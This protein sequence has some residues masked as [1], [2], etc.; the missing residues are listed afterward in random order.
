MKNNIG[1][2]M[3]RIVRHSGRSPALLVRAA[4]W[5]L[6]ERL[7]EVVP[8]LLCYVLLITLQDS[9]EA[10]GTRQ[11][12]G[13]ATLLAG[14]FVLQLFA[15]S[16]G[17]LAGF[18]GG[19]QIAAGY[20][21]RLLEHLHRLPWLT[22]RQYPAGQLSQLLTDDIKKIETLFTHLAIELVVTALVPL[23][24]ALG[25]LW[26]DW[27]L[28]LALLAGL[29]AAVL[30]I[31]WWRQ[32]F[33]AVSADK[34][35][36]MAQTAGKL[37]EFVLG[38]KTLR[39][40]NRGST[41]LSGLYEAFDRLTRASLRVET[42]G[43]GP[44]VGFRLL[45][46]MGLVA[47]LCLSA[48]R[49]DQAQVAPATLLLFLLLAHRLLLPLL[50]LA[51]QLSIARYAIQCETRIERFL[52][53]TPLTEPAAPQCPKGHEVAFDRVSFAYPDSPGLDDISFRV[54]PGTITAV[55]GPSGS[56]KSTL[57]NLV[58]RFGDPDD[59]VI[60]IGGVSLPDI[61]TD[62]VCQRLGMV[63]QQVQLF[64]GSIADNVRIGRPTASDEEVATAC[65]QAHCNDF[66]RALPQGY[67]TLVGEG[68]S[69]L[70]GGE[71]QRLSIARAFLKDAPILLLDEI[72][73][74]VDAITQHQIQASLRTLVSDKTVIVVAH[75]LTTIRDADQIL[76]MDK[77]RIVERGRHEALMA[78]QGLYYQ[79]YLAQS[80]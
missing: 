61:G 70:S 35:Q 10:I 15:A 75:R 33:A 22:V 18:L 77:G 63:F 46:E 9:A 66:I 49:L 4:A 36:L 53:Q 37:V 7:L 58:S 38:I 45:V 12:V 41:W 29:P 8:M 60:R 71:R 73:A 52:S 6:I 80:G 28:T 24:L 11:L 42:W 20:R 2:A 68:G 55:V 69:Q 30:L 65:R 27:Q 47:L 19:Y 64:S 67:Q 25:L 43:A 21:D 16:R 54:A 57:L 59:G 31:Q 50:E 72:T 14:I 76:V 56:G 48:W 39:L 3:L 78:K 1:S 5:Q 40:L 74:S 23:I 26:V 62:G 44:V 34:Q 51:Q 17:Q 32:R 13:L 79:L